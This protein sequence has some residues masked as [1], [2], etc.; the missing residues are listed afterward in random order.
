VDGS[1]DQ[2]LVL[3]AEGR[4]KI[5]IVLAFHNGKLERKH[6]GARIDVNG[7]VTTDGSNV[8]LKF[9]NEKI[10]GG[11]WAGDDSH[12]ALFPFHYEAPFVAHL[13]RCKHLAVEFSLYEE[14]PQT[15]TF[16]ISGLADVMK[17]SGLSI[18]APKA[19]KAR[20]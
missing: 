7:F 2:I 11:P 17:S 19:L 16:D 15:A 4:P 14:A 13:M 9:D 5:A 10:S 12:T 20:T 18:E 3:Y 1:R 8:R 6:V